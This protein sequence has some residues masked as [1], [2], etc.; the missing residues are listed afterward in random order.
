MI[1]S[2]AM[3]KRRSLPPNITLLNGN[4]YQVRILRGS[5]EFSASFS[6]REPDALS[7]A[8]SWRDAKL[9]LLPPASN[10]FGSYKST[11][12]K[13]KTSWYRVGISRYWS[14]SSR[15]SGALYLRFGVNWMD[16]EGV[17]RVKSFQVGRQ[18]TISAEQER[19]AAL[20]AEAFRDEWEH[21]Q[22]HGLAFDSAKYRDWRTTTLYPFSP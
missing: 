18:G 12:L 15:D 17:K 4:T 20:T 6:A 22:C 21:A 13:N 2:K 14:P 11:P 9:A 1:F 10:S 19:H 8:I 3:N 7:K 16:S 5:Q